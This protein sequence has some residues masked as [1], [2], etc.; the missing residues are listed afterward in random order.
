MRNENH[1]LISEIIQYKEIR[2]ERFECIYLKV[3]N[4]KKILLKCTIIIS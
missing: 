4:L 2:C 1:N 3:I